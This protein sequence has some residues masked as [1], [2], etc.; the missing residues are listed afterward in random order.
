MEDFYDAWLRYLPPLTGSKSATSA[1]PLHDDAYPPKNGGSPPETVAD[2]A[3]GDPFVADRKDGKNGGN[4]PFVTD[5]ADVADLAP[6]ARC[7]A[8]DGQGCPT[9]TPEHFGLPPRKTATR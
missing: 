6:D 2:V 5:V 7:T 4:K 1:T 9:C 3:G 8:C